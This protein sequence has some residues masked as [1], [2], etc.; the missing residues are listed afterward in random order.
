[1]ASDIARWAKVCL[2]CQKNIIS[3]HV[4][5]A[6]GLFEMLDNR[7]SYVHV[8]TVGP[9]LMVRGC[10]F[11]LTIIDRFTRWPEAL[12]LRDITASSIEFQCYS[13][14]ISRF[15]PPQVVTT[16]QGTQ[17]ESIIFKTLANLR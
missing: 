10:S 9:L 17:F 14:W 12:P 6:S 7:F 2:P 15:G 3:Q 11:L 4:K 5:P 13:G 1:M 16:D 8:D